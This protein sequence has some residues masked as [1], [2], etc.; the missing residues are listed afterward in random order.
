MS[1]RK[2]ILDLYNRHLIFLEE[3][4][5]ALKNEPA[6]VACSADDIELTK[7]LIHRLKKKI[8]TQEKRESW[9]EL[10]F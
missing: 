1:K 4:L 3:K 6:E 10:P 2:K 8:Q 5:S 9:L 7:L